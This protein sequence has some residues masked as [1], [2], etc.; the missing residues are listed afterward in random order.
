MA[1][2]NGPQE[3][4]AI[5]TLERYFLATDFIYGIGYGVQGVLYFIC[6]RY[7]WNQ[8]KI[9]RINMFMLAYITFLFL[10]S[11]IVEVA[12][13]HRTQLVFIENRNS[14]GGPW[15]YFEAS[16]GGT[17][18]ILGQTASVVL[19][20]MSELFMVW[21]CWVVWYSVSRWAAYAVVIFPSLM[22]VGSV[23]ASGLYFFSLMHPTSVI[24]GAHT[25]NW[26]RS[27]YTLMLG[28][29]IVV[30]ALILTR[31]IAHRRAVRKSLTPKHAG[32]YTSLIAMLIESAA[33]YSLI[34]AGCL[35]ATGVGSPVGQ[36]FVSFAISTQQISGYLIIAR[37]AHGEGWKKTTMSVPSKIV[38]RQVSRSGTLGDDGE[39]SGTASIYDRA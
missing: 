24:A 21:R 34:G 31:L 28:T 2:Y 13:A 29:N 27:Y 30:T 32:E 17:S 16:L 20:L 23:T 37:L 5:V 26:S 10:M 18:N 22:L 36:P 6:T 19:L 38:M 35:I 15:G 11:T 4:A 1:P 33:F 7:L 25:A 12:Q 8:R 14:P 3:P 39:D 9:R